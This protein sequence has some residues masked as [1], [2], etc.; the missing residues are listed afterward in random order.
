MFFCKSI[1]CQNATIAPGF[2]RLEEGQDTA[3][4]SRHSVLSSVVTE[5]RE[6]SAR[7]AHLCPCPTYRLLLCIV[8]CVFVFLKL[9]DG[10]FSK[11]WREAL[12]SP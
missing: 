11:K 9:N 2:L 1:V 5:E 7:I 8:C 10:V 4:F 3:L 12:P 6:P